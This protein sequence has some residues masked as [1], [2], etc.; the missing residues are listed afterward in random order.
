MMT[1]IL[2]LG[3][4]TTNTYRREGNLF[5]SLMKCHGQGKQLQMLHSASTPCAVPFPCDLSSV[6]FTFRSHTPTFF[7]LLYLPHNSTITSSFLGRTRRMSF[8]S[9][10]K[11]QQ[12]P[13]AQPSATVT[14]AQ[15]PSQALAQLSNA[16][17]DLN[18][19]QQQ[20]GSLRGDSALA[21]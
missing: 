8:F 3:I 4:S 12:Q 15:T 11:N 18:P 16:S 10:K 21:S 9:R 2:L 7:S 20:S 5:T 1:P 19:P 14:V 13:P 17:R 6:L